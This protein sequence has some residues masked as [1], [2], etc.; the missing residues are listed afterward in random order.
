[1]GSSYLG[2]S[3]EPQSSSFPRDDSPATSNTERGQGARARGPMSY[4]LA[5][6]TFPFS[7]FDSGDISVYIRFPSVQDATGEP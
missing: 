1:M 2:V 6:L 4:N 5:S 7:L 3:R